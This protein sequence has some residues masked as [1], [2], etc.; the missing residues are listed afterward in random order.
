MHGDL[1]AARSSDREP[2]LGT[3]GVI[4]SAPLAE[5]A[6]GDIGFCAKS[7]NSGL[8]QRSGTIGSFPGAF[9]TDSTEG[10]PIQPSRPHS[11]LPVL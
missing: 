3:G 4:P 11:D 9:E 1:T 7:E 8:I 6:T 2:I 5:R 10:G